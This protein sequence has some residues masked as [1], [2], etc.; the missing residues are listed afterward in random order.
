M[1]M[2][3][4]QFIVWLISDSPEHVHPLSSNVA[5]SDVGY[6]YQWHVAIGNNSSTQLVSHR[7]DYLLVHTLNDLFYAKFQKLYHCIIQVKRINHIWIMKEKQCSWC[8]PSDNLVK[9]LFHLKKL[10]NNAWKYSNFSNKQI[11]RSTKYWNIR[12]QL[13]LYPLRNLC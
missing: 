9:D 5:L 8:S 12:K 2:L 4:A 3:P 13:L 7:D 6:H 10:K 11:S 1:F